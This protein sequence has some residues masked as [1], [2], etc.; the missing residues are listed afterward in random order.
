MVITLQSDFITLASAKGVSPRRILWGHA[1][2]NSL[3]SLLTSIGVQLG[4]V[5]GGALVVEAFFDLDGMGSLLLGAIIAKDLFTV[6]SVAALLVACVVLVNLVIDLL[7]AV[8]D[9]RI[10]HARAL[11]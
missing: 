7:Y 10:R 8:I 3:F 11:G 2:R 4:A 5:I 6:Q 1:L 9:P